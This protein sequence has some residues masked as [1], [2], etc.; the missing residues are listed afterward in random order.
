MSTSC[1]KTLTGIIRICLGAEASACHQ[2][3]LPCRGILDCWH[4]TAANSGMRISN[5]GPGEPSF[6][7]FLR[8]RARRYRAQAH[9]LGGHFAAV[10]LEGGREEL[11]FVAAA[12]TLKAQR[13][14]NLKRV[15]LILGGPDGISDNIRQ[16][17]RSAVEEYTDFPLV[18]IALPGG[19]LHSYYA[20]AT[21]LVFHDQG[22]LIPYLEVQAG[23]PRQVVKSKARPAVRPEAD[24]PKPDIPEP[25]NPPQRERPESA[26]FPQAVEASPLR[27]GPVNALK[28]GPPKPPS[29]PPPAHLLA[30]RPGPI[31]ETGPAGSLPKALPPKPTSA[32]PMAEPCLKA[33]PPFAPAG[34]ASE[35]RG[36][37]MPTVVLDGNRL[38]QLQACTVCDGMRTR[39]LPRCTAW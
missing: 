39:H 25:E 29:C 9:K 34:A 8:R 4:R 17:I 7:S 33:P 12:K 31:S 3:S 21:V 10:I 24:K 20:L 22:L 37:R 36:W 19:I 13:E 28:A 27:P 1:A 16:Q 23:R 32:Q 15:L 38:L 6:L 2:A 11:K 30:H 18:G 35:F 5:G 26:A 14:A